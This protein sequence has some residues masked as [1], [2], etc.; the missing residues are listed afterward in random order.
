MRALRIRRGDVTLPEDAPTSPTLDDVGLT[1]PEEAPEAAP[2]DLGTGLTFFA[3]A[4]EMRSS[5]QGLLWPPGPG[6]SWFRLR[7]PVIDEQ[8]ATQAARV[9]AAADFG[10]G[11]SAPVS[12]L[13]WIYIN[14]DLQV[15][16]QREPVDDWVGVA[17]LS[18]AAAD[19]TA[20]TTSRL[21]DRTGQIGTAT[22][23][24]YVEPRAAPITPA[25]DG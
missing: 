25:G 8:P 5:H 17:S 2:P 24:L 13:D 10:N 6:S 14:A 12:Y 4:M 21:A 9:V 3:H 20:L 11:L 1:A 18:V 15:M 19:G 7:H 22:Q 16:I 23:S